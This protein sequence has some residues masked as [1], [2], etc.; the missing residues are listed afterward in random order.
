VGINK[1]KIPINGPFIPNFGL[2][3]G[4]NGAKIP[5]NGLFIPNFGLFIGNFG[6]IPG[7]KSNGSAN[8]CVLL[9][10]TNQW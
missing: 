3:I 2:F 6:S 10:N 8:R 7:M 9:K 4:I 5:I 1:A